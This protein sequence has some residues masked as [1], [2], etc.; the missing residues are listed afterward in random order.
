MPQTGREAGDFDITG[1]RQDAD[2]AEAKLVA[3]MSTP[4]KWAPDLP[5]ACESGKAHV[6]AVLT[7]DLVVDNYLPR[8]ELGRKL[9]ALRRAYVTTGGHLL[10]GNALDAEVQLRRNVLDGTNISSLQLHLHKETSQ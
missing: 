1:L 7:G 8:T 4:P 5:V 6:C 10:D 3:V 9:L 2:A